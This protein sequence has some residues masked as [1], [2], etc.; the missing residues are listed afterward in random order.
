MDRQT[1]N[2][3]CFNRYRVV[4]QKGQDVTCIYVAVGQKQSTVAQVVKKLEEHGAMYYTIVVNA[5][6]SEPAGLQFL[7][8]L[9]WRYNW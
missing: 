3:N 6:A 7:I 2:H 4:N 8:S 9:C 1:G 5:G